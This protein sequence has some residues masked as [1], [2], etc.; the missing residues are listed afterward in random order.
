LEKTKEFSIET[1]HLFTD[2]R[3]AY[4][5][6][7]REQLYNEMSEFNISNKLI[8]LTG[9]TMENTKSLIRIRSDLSDPITKKKGLIQGDLLACLLFN[10][11]LET[12]VRNAGIQKKET[13]FYKSVQLLAYADDTDTMVISRKALKKA[14]LLLERTAREMGLRI[15]KEKLNI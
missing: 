2:F 10:L 4:D 1:H 6:I 12:V 14:F 3:S 9:M 8:S 11:A 15:N 7:N 13:V 5:A